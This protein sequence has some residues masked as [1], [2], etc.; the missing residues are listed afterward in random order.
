MGKGKGFKIPVRHPV[1]KQ[2]I[3]EAYEAGNQLIS[4]YKADTQNI[5]PHYPLLQKMYDTQLEE[6]LTEPESRLITHQTTMHFR[7]K[8][9]VYKVPFSERPR[10]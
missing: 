10:S 6:R 4:E 2:E 1:T 8:P 3:A 5:A 7:F 9:I